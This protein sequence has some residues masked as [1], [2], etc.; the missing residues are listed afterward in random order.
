MLIGREVCGDEGEN[1]RRDAIDGDERVSPLADGGQCGRS[2]VVELRDCIEGEPAF[3]KD[4]QCSLSATFILRD[5]RRTV[6]DA[7]QFLVQG[8]DELREREALARISVN[9]HLGGWWRLEFE[10]EGGTPPH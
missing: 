6:R 3:R 9:G 10:R 5:L 2:V 4:H 1:F 8:E 7:F